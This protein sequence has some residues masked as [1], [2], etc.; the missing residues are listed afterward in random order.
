MSTPNILIVGDRGFIGTR[1]SKLLPEAQ[2][3]DLK[4][5]QD[6]CDPVVLQECEKADVV[7]LLAAIH[8]DQTKNM[9]SENLRI[10]QA[11]SKLSKPH[12]VFVSSAAVY[13]PSKSPHT[14]VEKLF[15]QT[16]YGKSKVLG[17]R[18]VKDLFDNFTIVRPSNVFGNGDGHGIIDIFK[19]GGRT[20]YGDG[21]QVRDYI[22]VERLTRALK[23]VAEDP[24]QY[25]GFTFNLSS[26]EGMSVNQVFDKYVGGECI[27]KDKRSYDV[28]YSVLDNGLAKEFDLL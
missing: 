8:L 23:K 14:E 9:Y 26:S 20:I 4:D 6:F 24:K 21:S 3:V 18:I 5:G 27:R 1:L 12:I 11:L 15:P 28:P 10:Y 2:G 17:E 22:S 25:N 13:N 7:I 19:R 16:L